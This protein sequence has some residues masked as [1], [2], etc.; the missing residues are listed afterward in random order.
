MKNIKEQLLKLK[1]YVIWLW[2]SYIWNPLHFR[3][4]KSR[5]NEYNKKTG[6]RYFVVPHTETRCMV[7]DND[8]IKHYNKQKGIKKININDLIR[9]AYYA[10]STRALVN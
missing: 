7:V 10:T 3:Y 4:M 5:A 1:A 8:Y 2:N 9:M 6:K